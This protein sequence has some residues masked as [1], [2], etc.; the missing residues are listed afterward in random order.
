SRA[1]MG[2]MRL[3]VFAALLVMNGLD[4]ASATDFVF[5]LP[6]H[7]PGSSGTVEHFV[8]VTN[9]LSEPATVSLSMPLM[10]WAQST[11]TIVLN[12]GQSQTLTVTSQAMARAYSVEDRGVLVSSDKEVV[13]QA[14]SRFFNYNTKSTG[15]FFVLPTSALSTEYLVV[16]HCSHNTCF[17]TVAATEPVVTTDVSFDLR[18][19]GVT[20]IY[21]GGRNYYNGDVLQMSLQQYQVMQL[22]CEGCDMSGTILTSTYPV[23]VVVGGDKTRVPGSTTRYDFI[24]GMLLPYTSGESWYFLAKLRD[25]GGNYYD[26]IK[27]GILRS[28]TTAQFQGQVFTSTVDRQ[29]ETFTFYNERPARLT[30]DGPVVVLQA[31]A[32]QV[33]SSS[34]SG[35][36]ALLFPRPTTRWRTS[37]YFA[38]PLVSGFD[39]IELVLVAEAWQDG[40][41]TTDNGAVLDTSRMTGSGAGQPA[42]VRLAMVP[43]QTGSVIS[44]C[45]PIS[46]FLYGLAERRAWAMP[47]GGAAEV[48]VATTTQVPTTE[49]TEASTEEAIITTTA[50]TSTMVTA[51]DGTTAVATEM[52]HTTIADTATA[53][54]TVADTETART[55]VAD[56][57]TAHIRIADTATAHATV[58]ATSLAT[59]PPASVRWSG[60]HLCPCRSCEWF[61]SRPQNM[62]SA[63]RRGLLIR[64]NLLVDR[65]AQSL[66]RRTKFS[67]GSDRDSVAPF[68]VLALMSVVLP[69]LIWICCRD[70]K[71][72]G[73]AEKSR[74]KRVKENY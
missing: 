31:S 41:L 45:G 71:T 11:Q 66:Y 30:V 8:L 52:A 54:T 10:T 74:K 2:K 63:F 26:H 46:G 35:D 21:Y 70:C 65:K 9:S 38:V 47:I 14:L 23:T 62:S 42:V 17:L 59:N 12:P 68:V 34:R 5:P 50:D 20:S 3:A 28:G 24:A 7:S 6:L 56:T 25:S 13:V 48:S 4:K 32:G 57:A 15:A 18:F 33:P 73:M 44:T 60:K 53:H 29:L 19:T 55:T 64:D 1:V 36:P 72:G 67:E 39:G 43:G 49:S 37:Y 69:N 40:C 16:T 51:M 27:V 22:R 61:Y 58:D